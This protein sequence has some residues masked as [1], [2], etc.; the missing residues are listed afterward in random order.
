M[1]ELCIAFSLTG[2][3]AVGILVGA[4]VLVFDRN[5][6]RAWRILS[7]LLIASGIVVLLKGIVRE[8][9]PPEEWWLVEAHGY[10]FPSG[11]AAVA[12][13]LALSATLGYGTKIGT[14]LW[15]YAACVSLS[16]IVLG[17]HYPHDVIGGALVG[18]VSV[19]AVWRLLGRIS[20]GR[21]IGVAL[22]SALMGISGALLDPSYRSPLLLAS[23]SGGAALGL[24]LCSLASRD[25][26]SRVSNK[27]NILILLLFLGLVFLSVETGL[28]PGLIVAGAIIVAA[29]CG[30]RIT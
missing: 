5:A 29:R 11:H 23:I 3:E 28:L 18:A 7:S 6:S 27:R 16:R 1:E 15:I 8:P 20:P 19:I 24:S 13:A 26:L 30:E 22:A 21:L 25:P 10:S 17:V 4:L 14:P 2:G 9:R 12:S